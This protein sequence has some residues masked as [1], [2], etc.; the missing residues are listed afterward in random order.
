MALPDGSLGCL[1]HGF[2]ALG[3][4]IRRDLP[5]T[6][7]PC[8]SSHDVVRV[9]PLLVFHMDRL[10]KHP[11]THAPL[12]DPTRILF[13]FRLCMDLGPGAAAPPPRTASG[14]QSPR[15]IGSAAAATVERPP[16]PATYRLVAVVEHVSGK[17]CGPKR[18]ESDSYV[19]YAWRA[20]KRPA[21]GAGGAC[22][23]AYS[24]LSNAATWSELS[25]AAPAVAAAAPPPV[26]QRPPRSLRPPHTRED[27]WSVAVPAEPRARSPPRARPPLQRSTKSFDL[28][29]AHPERARSSSGGGS[30]RPWSPT[31]PYCIP[32]GGFGGGGR[33]YSDDLP[34]PRS[35]EPPPAFSSPPRSGAARSAISFDL[36]RHVVGRSLNGEC[37]MRPSDGATMWPGAAGTRRAASASSAPAW[38]GSSLFHSTAA[39]AAA[40]ADSPLEGGDE[41]Y[42]SDWEELADGGGP[43]PPPRDREPS[44]ERGSPGG[45]PPPPP[46]D[47]EPSM[48]RG[49]PGG[50]GSLERGS[51]ERVVITMPVLQPAGTGM[52]PSSFDFDGALQQQQ[53]QRCEA[54]GGTAAAASP[55]LAG[56]TRSGGHPM[57]RSTSSSSVAAAPGHA[58]LAAAAPSA[59]VP[60]HGGSGGSAPPEPSGSGGV[61]R[62][63]MPAPAPAPSGHRLALPDDDAEDPG[64]WHHIAEDGVTVVPWQCVAKCE[65]Y[66]LLYERVQAAPPPLR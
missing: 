19:C 53:Q 54:A 45:E 9:P 36:D 29:P 63:D 3:R 59:S 31:P 48:E 58:P 27:A 49:S 22:V 12:K 17:R 21:T 13:P 10:T 28:P 4:G 24:E 43:P 1:P 23:D 50:G 35:F 25:N 55:Q 57:S 7:R 64:V 26:A 56:G 16:V 60:L 2:R 65:A 62:D 52:P 8:T 47:R 6:T 32:R 61:A 5:P 38:Q 46:R 20:S 39:A 44:M 34:R 37:G 33:M 66:M 11:H 15:S 42:A 51:A 40:E 18:P 14:F 30:R 41:P